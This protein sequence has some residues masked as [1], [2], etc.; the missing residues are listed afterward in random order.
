MKKRYNEKKNFRMFFRKHPVLFISQGYIE[1]GYIT[2]SRPGGF[3]GGEAYAY[4]RETIGETFQSLAPFFRYPVRIVLS[5]E[6]V[7]VASFVMAPGTELTREQVLL[8]AEE[9]IPENLDTTNWDFRTMH[10]SQSQNTGDRV[11]QVAVIERSFAQCLEQALEE[12]GFV[13]E[14]I[15]PESYALATLETNRAGCTVIVEQNRE[16]T[17]LVA[18]ENGVVLV[19]MV[20]PGILT[21]CSALEQF[22][23][24]VHERTSKQVNRVVLSHVVDGNA[25]AEEVQRLGYECTIMDYNPLLG[26]VSESV[27]GK[28]S[29]VLNLANF[30]HGPTDSWWKRFRHKK[31]F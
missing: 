21:E 13:V 31:N 24:F 15:L 2:A 28:D 1:S 8:K 6:L 5:E 29:T 7:Y 23:S 17:L 10:F 27:S 4:T 11:V 22:V 25:R 12:T 19:T 3:E 14:S 9:L 16:N 20:H 18:V 30:L 26:L